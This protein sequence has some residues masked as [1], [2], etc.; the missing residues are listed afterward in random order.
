MVM[1]T[2]AVAWPSERTIY[3][4]PEQAP[5]EIAAA[6][7]TAAQ[8]HKRV[9]LDFGGNWC[10]DCIVLDMY[11]HNEQNRPL[12]DKNFVLVHVNVG[13]YDANLDL[14]KKYGIPL[15]KGVPAVAVLS[16]AGKLLY[17]QRSGEFEK[18]R[19]MDSGEVTRF[20]VQWKPGKAGCSM[21][22]VNC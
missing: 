1:L 5:T 11:F 12:L 21:M 8:D 15:E 17:S 19:Q 10:G 3:P 20:L 13:H 6:L 2:A 16:A 18:M 14:A 22:A 9:L 7:K 4:D